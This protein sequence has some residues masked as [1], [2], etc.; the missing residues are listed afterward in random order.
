MDRSEELRSESVKKLLLKFSIPAIIGMIVNALYNIVDRMFIGH[1]GQGVGEK[2]LTGVG[3]T[4]PISTIIMA[5]GMLVGIGASTLISIKLGEGNKKDAEKILNIAFIL[6]IIIS[7]IISILGIIFLDT[8][9]KALG[10]DEESIFYAKQYISIIILGAILQNIGFGLNNIIRSEG[11]PKI[12][13]R[14]ML[15]GAISNTI[16]DP[17]FIFDFGL[18]LGIRGAAIATIISQAV[19]STLVMHYFI[20]K[21]SGSILKI[22]KSN[23]KPNKAIVL[24]ILTIG[25]SPFSMQIAASAVSALYNKGLIVYGGN[26]AVAAMSIISSISLLIFMPIFGINQGSQPILGYNYGAKSYERVKKTLRFAI[27]SGVCIASLGFILVQF[28]PHI[29]FKAF[30]NDAP[31]LTKLGS[32]GMRIDL[33]FLPIVG[34]QIVASNY[35][36]AVGKAKISIFLSFLRQVIVLIPIILILPKF[37]GLDGIW[38]SQPIADIVAA[39]LTSFFLFKEMKQINRIEKFEKNKKEII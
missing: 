26:I 17:I 1:I 4:M 36:Q 11:N 2:A 24:E 16:L 32:R 13:M 27:I 12:A 29:L 39:L 5:F 34:Y 20:S 31:E 6:S 33:I 30:A 37:F 10:A 25:L 8:I 23:L 22:K 19:N 14:T 21:N 35:F 28:F 3:I 15:V 7:V 38:L 9:L 18:G